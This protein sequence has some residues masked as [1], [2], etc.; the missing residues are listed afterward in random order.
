M[1]SRRFHPK[2]AAVIAAAIVAAACSSAGPATAPLGSTPGATSAGLVTSPSPRPSPPASGPSPAPSES[3]TVGAG[4]EWVVFQSLADQFDPAADQ[5][6]IEHDDTIFLVRTD[7]TGLHRLPPVDLVG[8][9]IRPRWSPDG[10]QIAFIRG[11]LPGDINELWIINADGSGGRAVYTC[12]PGC[13]TIGNPDWSPDGKALFFE[14]DSDV[15]AEGPPRT[16]QMFR[17]DLATHETKP[18]FT[19]HDTMTAEQMALS[20]DGTQVVFSRGKRDAETQ[21]ALFVADSNGAHERRITAWGMAVAYPGWS[22]TG[23]IVFNT[24]D[25]RADP[26]TTAAANIYTINPDGSN[27]RQLTSY[28]ANDT[29]ATQPRWTQDGRGIVYTLVTRD[30]FDPYGVRTLAYMDADGSHARLLTPEPIIGTHPE[31]RPIPRS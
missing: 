3:T 30:A 24:H 8:S 18:A 13:N 14:G 23:R 7:G 17:Y 22:V 31:L 2:S 5:D 11:H 29:R 19:R 27:L 20:P 4:E 16:F 1:W 6:G 28:H 21:N 10:N 9:E 12:G 26:T 25:L 15:P